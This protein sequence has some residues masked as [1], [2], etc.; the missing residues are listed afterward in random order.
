M[1]SD[2]ASHNAFRIQQNPLENFFLLT[3][4]QNCTLALLKHRDSFGK[5]K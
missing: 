2:I 5:E 1:V 4:Y 3:I